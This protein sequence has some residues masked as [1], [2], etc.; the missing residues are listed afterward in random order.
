VLENSS[1]HTLCRNPQSRHALMWV[2]PLDSE[3][4]VYAM[5]CYVLED[6]LRYST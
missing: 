3:E 4:R 1:L 2:C 6:Y 5:Q